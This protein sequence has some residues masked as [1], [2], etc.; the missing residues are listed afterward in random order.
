MSL[1]KNYTKKNELP[2]GSLGISTQAQETVRPDIISPGSLLISDCFSLFT[3]MVQSKSQHPTQVFK[4]PL[5]RFQTLA[6]LI[7]ACLF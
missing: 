4:A 3:R 6:P 5:K 1:P 2:V 7:L